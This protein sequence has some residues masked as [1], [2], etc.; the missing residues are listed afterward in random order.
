MNI[1]TTWERD[2]IER[3]VEMRNNGSSAQEI[4]DAIGKTRGSVK[5]FIERHRDALKLRPHINNKAPAKSFR[6]EWD[7]EWYGSV[8]FG[9]WMITKPWN[10][11]AS[12]Q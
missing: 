1:N 11:K 6:P 10:T 2:K 12:S 5:M 4:A 9:H 8:P 3:L 7:R